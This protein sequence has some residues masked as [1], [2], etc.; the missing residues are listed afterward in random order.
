MIE[1]YFTITKTESTGW[2]SQSEHQKKY[3]QS[4]E[5]GKGIYFI[6]PSFQQSY[7]R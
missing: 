7:D 4:N 2:D 6:A 5:G 1:Y 3:Q